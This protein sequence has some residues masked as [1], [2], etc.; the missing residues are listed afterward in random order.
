METR[1]NGWN[2][3]LNGAL[4]ARRTATHYEI[5]SLNERNSGTTE[6]LPFGVSTAF[7]LKNM[8]TKFDI[9]GTLDS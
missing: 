7:E 4:V 5:I 9:T 1:V 2:R 8:T 3:K 6:K